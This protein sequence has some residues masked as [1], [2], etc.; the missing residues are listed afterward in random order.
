MIRSHTKGPPPSPEQETLRV[1][2]HAMPVQFIQSLEVEE[3]VGHVYVTS[4][5]TL[6]SSG[7]AGSSM[8]LP[9]AS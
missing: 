8:Q 4:T 2:D 9:D 5:G 3:K 6:S 7:V 1:F